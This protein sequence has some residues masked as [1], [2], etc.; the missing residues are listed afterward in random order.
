MGL[1][2]RVYVGPYLETSDKFRL[3]KFN[4]IISEVRAEDHRD[5][6]SKYFV[7]N[8]NVDGIDRQMWFGAD[9]DYKVFDMYGHSQIHEEIEFLKSIQEVILHLE[10]NDIEHRIRWGIIPEYS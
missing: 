1:S 6:E 10:A 8:Q 2:F 5:G 9:H 3:G 7:P 4:K